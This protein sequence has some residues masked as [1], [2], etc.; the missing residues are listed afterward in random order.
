MKSRDC[1]LASDWTIGFLIRQYPLTRGC[2]ERYC[3]PLDEETQRSTVSDFLDKTF[4]NKPY[5]S[6]FRG[7]LGACLNN[8]LGAL[9]GEPLQRS[10][11]LMDHANGAAPKDFWTNAPIPMELT[12]D[13]LGLSAKNGL[14][15]PYYWACNG[16]WCVRYSGAT[17]EIDQLN[18]WN[19][20]GG[21]RSSQRIFSNGALKF[22]AGNASHSFHQTELWPFGFHNGWGTDL[23]NQVTL[24]L[25][26]K[27]LFVDLKGDEGAWISLDWNARKQEDGT[28]W[29]VIGWDEPAQ[30]WVVYV[31][32][33]CNRMANASSGSPRQEGVSEEEALALENITPERRVMPPDRPVAGNLYLLLSCN[34]QKP[35]I[36]DDGSWRW[37]S[38]SGLSFQITAGTTYQEA[39]EELERARATRAEVPK[40]CL[41]H[42]TRIKERAPTAKMPGHP[43]IAT[44]LAIAPLLME[45]LKLEGNSGLRHSAAPQ[46]YIDTHTSLMAM[47][48]MLYSGDFEFVD[49]FLNFLSDPVRRGPQGNIGTNFFLDGTMD[50]SFPDWTFNDVS[51]LALIGHLHWHG[52]GD[53]G[54]KHYDVGRNHLLRILKDTDPETGLFRSRGYWPDHP[55]KDV[56]RK[57]RPW[58]VNEA[59]IW[60]EAL[61][62]WE[63]LGMRRGDSEFAGQVRTVSERL[64]SVFV[65]LFYD[66]ETGLF[67]D[68]VDPET[69]RRHPQ[70]S[71]FGLHFLYGV[72]G[73]ELI[74]ESLARRLAQAAYDGFYDPSWKL[75][76]TC[77]PSGPFYSPF[78]SIYIHW[79]QGLAKLF[80]RARHLEGLRAIRDS[81]EFHFGK[82]V[83]FPE[84]FNMKPDI[85]LEGHGAS[86]WFCET[87]GT[88]CQVILEALYGI[89]PAPDNLGIFP[90]GLESGEVHHLP[91]AHSL[92]SFDYRGTG[93]HVTGIAIDGGESTPSWVFPAHLLE[94]GRHI[95]EVRRGK[96]SPSCPV[97]LEAAGLKLVDAKAEGSRCVLKFRGPGRAQLKFWSPS[98]PVIARDGIR[99][100]VAWDAS[101]QHTT[102]EVCAEDDGEAEISA[103]LS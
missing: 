46:G 102:V 79:L 71:L 78:E 75:F 36:M 77:L 8:I 10:W 9:Y 69:K 40:R 82:F 76:R 25:E 92:W 98:K 4:E 33:I 66:P 68:S 21:H 1:F 88:R 86:G 63:I 93:R 31:G 35:E 84:N 95:V 65:S 89:N 32:Y 62:N 56:G 50:D 30:A 47:R 13:G 103:A 6:I 101:S 72:F 64:K 60:Y 39:S 34:R 99:L 43:N 51:F 73:H 37:S 24:C 17:G 59:G 16:A 61:R 52:R 12:A 5:G 85:S 26:E 20:V 41:T 2:L 42:Y 44:T 22:G 19:W 80:R 97:L 74:D 81:F 11:D 29:R 57:G 38:T 96:D 54:A 28:I 48:G 27:S 100:E 94:G 45:S 55:L 14:P 53:F 7:F 67:C 58:T 18:C 87:L 49:R 70:Y 83:N 15:T 91:I 3:H 90:S 23:K